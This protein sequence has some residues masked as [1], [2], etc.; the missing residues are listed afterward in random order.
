MYIWKI[1]RCGSPQEIA[2]LAAVSGIGH[3]MIKIADG[4]WDYG[5]ID[6]RD[7]AFEL[8]QACLQNDIE[9]WG[10]QYLYSNAPGLEADKA[11]ERILET[12]VIGFVIDAEKECKGRPAAVKQ[13]C[14]ALRAEMDNL[15]IGLASYRFPHLHPKL[16]W[17]VF[18]NYVDFDMPQVYWMGAHNSGAQLRASMME[19]SR[20]RPALPYVPTGA[21][22]SEHGWSPTVGE[23]IEFMDVCGELG[24]SVFNFWEWYEA[25]NNEDWWEAITGYQVPDPP[26]QADL[27]MVNT[28]VLNLRN[29][30][31]ISPATIIGQTQRGKVWKVTG[32]VIDPMGREWIQS[33]PTVHLAGWLCKEI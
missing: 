14:E 25:Y 28:A 5:I 6:G 2:D 7:L 27:V 32:R 20:M 17:S 4:Q 29:A 15:P 8:A 22:F 31:L 26:P 21:A 9:A 13:Y 16:P 19:F 23:I 33:G 3:V 24:L 10:W 12:G 11:V 18:R 1:P 30:P